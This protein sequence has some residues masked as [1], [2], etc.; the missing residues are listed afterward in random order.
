[1][2][3]RRKLS[4]RRLSACV[5][6]C[7]AAAALAVALIILMFGNAIVNGY[8]KR[9]VERAF[10]EA[11]PGCALRIGELDYALAASRLVATSVTLATTN[12]TLKIGRISLTGVRWTRLLSGI[13]P[14]A[15]LLVSLL[16]NV[17]KIRHSNAPDASGALKHGEINYTRRPDDE[18]LQFAWFALRSGVLDAITH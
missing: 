6:L 16:E 5:G 7:L 17:L 4:L 1:V 9:K 12:V 13:A 2:K 11:H 15:D 8:A 3:H 18:F 14:L 10:A